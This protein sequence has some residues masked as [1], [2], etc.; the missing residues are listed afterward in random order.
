M[1]G[2]HTVTPVDMHAYSPQKMQMH[3]YQNGAEASLPWK[4]VRPYLESCA[5]IVQA[6]V[7]RPLLPPVLLSR[8]NRSPSGKI[9]PNPRLW[10]NYLSRGRR[11]DSGKNSKNRELTSTSEHIELSAKLLRSNKRNINQ[12][13]RTCAWLRAHFIKN[14]IYAI[15]SRE[16]FQYIQQITHP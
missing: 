16:F 14:S 7:C 1:H 15:F 9:R 11:F 6:V 13:G 3:S 5:S 12:V 4:L 10:C 8:R 2:A